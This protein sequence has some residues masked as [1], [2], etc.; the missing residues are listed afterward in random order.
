MSIQE[1]KDNVR[2]Y[3]RKLSTPDNRWYSV[4]G[5]KLYVSD[6]GIVC[7][8]YGRARVYP[9]PVFYP[10]IRIDQLGRYFYTRNNNKYTRVY[11]ADCLAEGELIEVSED[12]KLLWSQIYKTN[13]QE[14]AEAIAEEAEKFAL[15]ML[16][17]KNHESYAHY[18]NV[19]SSAIEWGLKH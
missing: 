12:T 18:V 16:G 11:V 9:A 4:P 2:A 10:T 15:W 17:S 14:Q 6:E 19:F 7:S 5:T 3:L 1:Y 13:E 8:E